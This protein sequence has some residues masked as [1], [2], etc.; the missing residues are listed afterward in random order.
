MESCKSYSTF[1]IVMYFRFEVYTFYGKFYVSIIPEFESSLSIL[2]NLAR[3]VLKFCFY[4]CRK[5]S[6]C[7]LLYLCKIYF[8]AWASALSQ[9]VSSYIFACIAHT[10]VSIGLWPVFLSKNVCDFKLYWFLFTTIITNRTTAVSSNR[11]DAIFADLAKQLG[12]GVYI[13]KILPRY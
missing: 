13:R 3:F 10:S 12:I 2:F 6:N 1:Y 4:F 9:Y 5:K 8:F 11:S 7:F